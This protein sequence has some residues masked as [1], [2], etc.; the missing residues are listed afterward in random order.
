MKPILISGIQPSGET[1]I[2]NYL[3]ALKN[4]VYLQN[5]G[6]YQCYFFVADLHSITENYDPAQKYRQIIDVVLNYLAIGINP[7]K[8]VI[9]IQSQIPEHSELMWILNT[10]TPMGELK[11]MTQF[12]DKSERQKENVNAGLFNYPVLQAADIL[13]YDAEFVPV[14][15]DQLQHLEL[16][17]T[18]ARKFNSKFPVG[19]KKIFVEPKPLLAEVPKLMSLSDPYKKMSKSMPEGCLFMDDSPDEI[20]NKIKKAVT[21]SGTEIIYDSEKKPAISNLIRIYG[22]FS[23]LSPKEVEKK[24]KEKNYGQFKKELADLIVESLKPFQVKKKLLS[25][26]PSYILKIIEKGRKKA[27]KKVNPKIKQIKKAIGL[28]K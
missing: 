20:R 6:R 28:E 26:K 15:E 1:H 14:G 18:L 11:R 24:F 22:G 3:G 23:K 16:A 5:S 4:F 2:G 19:R 10:I 8:S 7:E 13:L 27:E 12:K 25:K 17:R 21:D 9:F